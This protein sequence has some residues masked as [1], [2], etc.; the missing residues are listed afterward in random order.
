[1]SQA[2]GALRQGVLY[3]LL[4]RFHKHDMREI[5]VRQFM[6]RYR[7]DSAQAARVESL[8]LLLA[9]QLLVNVVADEAEHS[10]HILSWA[11]RLH[12]VGISVAHSGY[13]KHSA[14]I[15]GNADMPGFSR[16]EQERLSALTLGHRGSL[17]KARDCMTDP[18]DFA[19]LFA[20][21][22]AALF[23]R[24]RSDIQL[25]QLE[26]RLVSSD[27]SEFMLFIE[28]GWLE[29]NPLTDTALSGEIEQWATLGFKLRVKYDKEGLDPSDKAARGIDDT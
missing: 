6:Q 11:A 8:A 26:A 18:A 19:L 12:E 3:D 5:T 1:M 25:P 17:T 24:C 14:Y 13:H 7:V 2:M 22:L 20:L 4:G 27:N 21:R 29:R 16:R 28:P 10:L 9:R 15:L 23:H